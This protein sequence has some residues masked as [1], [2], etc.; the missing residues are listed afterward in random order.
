MI[1]L[2]YGQH[3]DVYPLRV[4]VGDLGHTG[5]SRERVYCILSH[6]KLTTR[7]ADPE[8]LYAAIARTMKRFVNTEPFDYFIATPREV[9]LA[10]QDLARVR[11]RH[12][13]TE[14]RRGKKLDYVV[15]VCLHSVLMPLA[16]TLTISKKAALH[17]DGF[18]TNISPDLTC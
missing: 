18:K 11:K 12:L 6:K 16:L 9:L 5:A 13:K 7:V 14:T 8:N 2:L 10:A 17:F 4:D 15:L 3:Y 1:K